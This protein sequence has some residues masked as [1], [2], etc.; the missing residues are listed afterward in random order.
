MKKVHTS[1]RLKEIMEVRDLKQADVLRMAKSASLQYGVKLTKTDLSQYVSGKTEPGQRKLFILS[2]AL[3]VNPAWLM[4]LDV[5]MHEDTPENKKNDTISDIILL[6]RKDDTLLQMFKD[7]C[8]LTDEQ[9]TALQGIILA[10]KQ[11]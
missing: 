1:V 5:P 7:I 3:G 10:L 11:R 4:G 6:L 9:R 8:D 2:K